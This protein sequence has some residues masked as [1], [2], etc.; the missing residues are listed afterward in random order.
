MKVQ[1]GKKRLF[2][3][4]VIAFAMCMVIF[5][6]KSDHT[7]A[8]T[9]VHRWSS[10]TCTRPRTCS[11]CG[12]TQGAPLGHTYRQATC[13]SP[14]TCVRCGTARGSALGHSYRAAT[15]TSPAT[16]T[17][18]QATTGSALGHTYKPATCTSPATCTRCGKA[19][20]TPNGHVFVGTTCKICGM[21]ISSAQSLGLETETCE[22]HE[23]VQDLKLPRIQH[24]T[25]IINQMYV[26]SRGLVTLGDTPLAKF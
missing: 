5:A 21:P 1:K 18:C 12:M 15:C 25:T 9:H 23:L 8:A 2:I 20:G 14:A 10:A 24:F 11:G 26:Q 3:K 22:I 16:C 4:L 7:S 17:R 6:C 19:V 13:T